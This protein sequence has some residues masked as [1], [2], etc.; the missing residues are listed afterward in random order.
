MEEEVESILNGYSITKEVPIRFH[1]SLKD[2]SIT[3]KNVKIIIKKN[4]DKEL[5]NN[6]YIPLTINEMYHVTDNRSIIP[7]IKNRIINL[8]KKFLKVH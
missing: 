1:K 5:I 6:R 3:S 7:K 4:N 2:L 8:L